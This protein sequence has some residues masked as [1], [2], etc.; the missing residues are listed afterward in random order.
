MVRK[1]L[2]IGLFSVIANAAVAQTIVVK[3]NDQ[4]PMP[5]TPEQI[6]ISIG[7]NTF[8]PSLTDTSDQA[9]KSAEN[10][11]RMVYELADHECAILR[12]VIA[13]DCRLDSINV[14]IQRVAPNQNF[15]QQNVE[16]FNINGNIG[17][18]IVPK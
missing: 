17:L 18:R 15:G 16:G 7:L 4:S 8:A 2:L 9:L 3:P 10:A 13:S 6:R 5:A 1:F 11:R 12:D 14:N